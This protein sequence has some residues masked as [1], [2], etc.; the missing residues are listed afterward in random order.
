MSDVHTQDQ[1]NVTFEFDDSSLDDLRLVEIDP[2]VNFHGS[3]IESPDSEEV[4][5]I[6]VGSNSNGKR[7]EVHVATIGNWPEFKTQTCYTRI[8]I[9]FDGWTKIPYPCV[10][11]RTCKKAW[12]LTITYSGSSDLPGNI[13]RIISECAKLALVP[14]IPLLLA[15]QVGAA[16]SAFLAGFKQCLIAKGIQEAARFGAGFDS[17]STCGGWRRV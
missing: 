9:P 3:D 10:W 15:G 13:E 11:T 2:N 6:I 17:R 5:G 16:I 8:K 1:V 4:D 14:A 7:W 12:Y